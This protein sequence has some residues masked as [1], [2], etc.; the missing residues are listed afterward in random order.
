V[1]TTGRV[2]SR[3]SYW[4]PRKGAPYE[5]S[6]ASCRARSALRGSDHMKRPT[7]AL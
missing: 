7:P 6:R 4:A 1:R 2:T 5:S 3:S